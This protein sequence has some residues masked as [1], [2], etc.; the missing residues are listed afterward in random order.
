MQARKAPAAGNGVR[1]DSHLPLR[2][3]LLE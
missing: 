1:A 3:A 2:A